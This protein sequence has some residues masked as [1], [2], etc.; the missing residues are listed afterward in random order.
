MNKQITEKTKCTGCGACVMVCTHNAI[1]MQGDA[2]GFLYPIIDNDKCV[3][4]NTCVNV[5]NARQSCGVVNRESCYVVQ[6]RDN[7]SRRASSSG[8]IFG[9]IA[10][11]WI[12]LGGYV[13]GASF[14]YALNVEHICVKEIDKLHLIQK[15]KYVQSN[16]KNTFYEVKKLLNMNKMVCYS[17][18][19]CQ[20]AGLKA[21]LGKNYDNLLCID[22]I[23]Q[24][25][26]GPLVWKKHIE[27]LGKGERITEFDFRCKDE[28]WNHLC[29]SYKHNNNKCLV[30]FENDCYLRAF[31]ETE[32]L[33]ECCY[34]CMFRGKKGYSDI[35]LGDCWGYDE[36]VGTKSDNIG[37][38]V[39][40]INTIRSEERR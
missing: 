14:D 13:Y 9:E 29:I 11:K 1:K 2:E 36:I 26:P 28:G 35:T 4:C 38:S 5:C 17:G 12:E 7:K 16:L 33:R 31:D 32:I 10:R 25:V 22:V 19:P 20:I 37:S 21:F 24:G 34:S 3:E 39:V 40:I 15:S 30:D 18:T 6:G 27:R 23:C 8:G